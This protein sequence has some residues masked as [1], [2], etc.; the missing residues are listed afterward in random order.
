MN[1]LESRP[2]TQPARQCFPY[3]L[4]H[5]YASRYQSGSLTVLLLVL[6]AGCNGGE[7]QQP[8]RS[9]PAHAGAEQGTVMAPQVSLMDAV[10]SGNVDAVKRHIA[11]GTNLESRKQT[12]GG[13]PLNIACMLGR[14]EVAKVLIHAGANIESKLNEQ[15]TPLFNAAFFCQRESVELLL[16]HNAGDDTRGEV[17]PGHHPISI[18]SASAILTD[19]K[20]IV[21][22]GGYEHPYPLDPEYQCCT[23]RGFVVAFGPT[24]GDVAWKYKV[25]EQPREFLKTSCNRRWQ[26]STRLHT[27]S[28][29]P[30]IGQSGRI[31]IQHHGG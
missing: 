6:L 30:R 9:P 31:A 27:R 7:D 10:E 2:N 13:T 19:G 15:T 20:V 14:T 1:G 11:A 12:E 16:K 5:T 8:P 25:G 18:F 24:S 23:G 17:F 28:L 21:G 29:C 26:R 4:P 22:G 3:F